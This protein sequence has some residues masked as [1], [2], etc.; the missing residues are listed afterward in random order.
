MSGVTDLSGT[1]ISGPP[2]VTD[3]TFP[4][5][6]S[7]AQLRTSTNP[8][9]WSVCTGV[10]SRSIASPGAYVALNGVGPTGDVTN[11]DFLYLRSST[12]LKLRLT[13]VDGLG[14]LV[15]EQFFSG[16]KIIEAPSSN[17]ITLV[18][19]KGTATIEYL[20]QGQT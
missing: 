2:N 18:E 4:S 8:K 6:Q 17:C 5:M 1:I 15:S 14:I 9:G 10:L 20:A 12:T 16:L 19:V 11:A 7:T 13:Q 3:T